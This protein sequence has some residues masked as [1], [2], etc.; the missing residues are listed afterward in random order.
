MGYALSAFLVP[1]AEI[2]LF[3]GHGSEELLRECLDVARDRLADL[4]DQLFDEDEPDDIKHEQ[5]FRELFT[6]EI[7]AKSCGARYGWAFETLCNCL[8]TWLS[9]RG[10]SPCST[11]WYQ[12][13]DD[14]LAASHVSLRFQDLTSNCPI[15]IPLS[16][17]W[18][19][20]G[21]WS[22]EQIDESTASIAR[23]ASDAAD[24]DIAEALATV[25]EWFTE[26]A[27]DPNLMIVGFHG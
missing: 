16:D 4:D 23:L 26:A 12:Q 10:F 7:S 27:N 3:P 20:I 5:A 14:Y 1:R 21:H 9:N 22:H 19:M 2:L 6:G 13:L 17:D 8:G 18:P 11:K 24:P 15:D 25:V